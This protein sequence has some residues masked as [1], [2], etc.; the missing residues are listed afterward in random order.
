M[1]AVP[2]ITLL[3]VL[4]LALLLLVLL[5][6]LLLLFLLPLMLLLLFLPHPTPILLLLS[7]FFSLRDFSG[8]LEITQRCTQGFAG[9]WLRFADSLAGFQWALERALARIC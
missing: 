4:L 2:A 3:Q 7:S 9:C 1:G 6:F 8:C 5:L